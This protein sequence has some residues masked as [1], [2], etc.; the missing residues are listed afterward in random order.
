[1]DRNIIVMEKIFS[2]IIKKEEK[3]LLLNCVHNKTKLTKL[4]KIKYKAREIHFK[5]IL[6]DFIKIGHLLSHVNSSKFRK[7]FHKNNL[8]RS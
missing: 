3:L 5:N 7:K 1:M 8:H 4:K 6:C 2:T